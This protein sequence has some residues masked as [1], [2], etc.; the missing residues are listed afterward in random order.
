MATRFYLPS[1]GAPAVTPPALP[2][3]WLAGL[4]AHYAA[5]TGIVRTNTALTD[6]SVAETQA[7]ITNIPVAAF[8]SAPLAAQSI[9]GNLT[10]SIRAIEG[11]SGHDKSLNIGVYLISNDGTAVL[12][13]LYAGH[14]VT[15]INST[16]DALGQEMAS[17]AQQ[18]RIIPSTAITTQTAASG[19]RLMILAGY[20]AHVASGTNTNAT[21][22]LGDPTGPAD[23][24]LASGLTTDL[25]PWVELSGTLT[26]AGG[27]SDVTGSASA[28]FTFDSPAAGTRTVKGAAT[29]AATFDAPAVGKR[30]V[31][32]AATAGFIFDATASGGSQ[33]NSEGSASAAF[34]FN[35]PAVGRRTV[36]GSAAAGFIF[37]APAS[38]GGGPLVRA[39]MDA[40]VVANRTGE[41]SVTAA[42]TATAAA[43][44]A[45]T[46][47]SG[48][49]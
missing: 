28:A 35:A 25:V 29:A 24:G 17:A 21:L 41:S 43:T 10:A 31:K 30:T 9:S 40:A 6:F 22:R 49:S 1:S 20:R 38:D 44:A 37:N 5:P 27:G 8:V 33:G 36:R 45:N 42:R 46:Q 34:L 26:F 15:P 4:S 13:T 7:T 32:G 19:D 48:V 3:G 47:T 12:S 23:F 14:T 2:A 18:T 39:R 11:G 16:P